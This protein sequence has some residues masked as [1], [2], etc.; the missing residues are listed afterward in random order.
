MTM[1]KG[2]GYVKGKA[3]AKAKAVKKARRCKGK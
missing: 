3:K 2:K 1:P